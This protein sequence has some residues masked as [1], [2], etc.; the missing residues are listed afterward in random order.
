[1]TRGSFDD[2]RDAL[3]AF[4]SGWDRDRYESG[5][6]QD[7]QLDQWARG[8]VD[9]YF[10][11]YSSWSQL[12]DA[13]WEAMSYRSMN[14]LGFV[15][16]QFG[17]ALLID[18]GYYDD[19]VFY[20]N[21]AASNTWDGTWTGKNGVTSLED[22]MTK[23]AQ[24][25]AIREAFGFNLKIIQ[26][27]LANQGKSL[28]DYIGTTR[29]YVEG[30]QN[31]E[32]PLTLTGIMAAAHLRGAWGTLNLLLSGS[33]ST[34]E[35][36]TS[37]LRYVKQFGGYDAPSIEDVIAYFTDRKTGDE[38]LGRPGS[39]DGAPGGGLGDGATKEDADVV[40]TWSWGQKTVKTDFDP[41]SDSIFID[42]ISADHL[43]ISEVNGSTVFS[44]PSNNQSL[45]LQGVALSD[46]T[47]E[48]FTIL[49]ASAAAKVSKLI[50][51]G[52]S[53]GG[54]KDDGSGDDPNVD[55]LV[56]DSNG[57]DESNGDEGL[58]RPGSDDGA[59]GGGLGDGA[60]KEDADVVITWSWGQ[61][62]VKT[63]FDPAS[64]SIFIDWISADHL[65]ISEVNGSTVFSIP[66]N[67][68]SLTL[69]GVALSDLTRENFT[70]LD[71]SAAAK[72]SKLIANGDSGGGSKDDGSGDDPNVDNLVDDSNGK[73]ESNGDEGGRG[74][75]HEDHKDH[76]DHGNGHGN[77]RDGDAAQMVMIG[78]D[79]VSREITDFDP[80]KDMVHLLKGVTGDRFEISGQMSGGS[81]SVRIVVSNEDG[82]PI[83]V[84]TLRGV[85]IDDLSL[86]NFSVAEQTALNEVVTAINAT[87]T[88]PPSDGGGFDFAYDSDG[89][90]PPQT[91]GST[92]KGGVKYEADINADDIVNFDPDKDEIDFGDN[93][94][95]AMILTKLPSGEV[96]IDTPWSS[97]IQI[98]QGVS[99]QDLSLEN[100]GIVRNEH[101]RQD[102]GGVLSWELGVGPRENDTVYI[103]SHEYGKHETIDDFDPA[104]MKISFL[105][106]GTREQ[107]SVRD[108]PEGLVIQTLPGGQSFTFTGLRLADLSPGNLEFHYDQVME[109]NLEA[110]FGFDQEDVTLVDRTALLTPEAPAGQTTDGFQTRE[111]VGTPGTGERD[112]DSGGERDGG[113]GGERDS[114]SGG[115]RDSGSGGELDDGRVELEWN[116]AATEVIDGFDPENDI[117][118]FGQMSADHLRITEEDGDLVIKVL[119]NGGQSYRLKDVQAEDMRSENL[120]AAPNNNVIARPGGVMEQLVDL[121]FPEVGF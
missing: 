75:G 47:R 24:E 32:V 72:V 52:D 66:S 51:N 120:E 105:Y 59:P 96:A 2:F 14:T 100:F 88:P 85:D 116:W 46:L 84:T 4:E 92:A 54:S 67:N 68:Q 9:K 109:D 97:A 108:T 107:L 41:A 44:I 42:W 61:K 16:Y 118:D 77:G 76:K 94:V 30:G 29:S 10:P 86:S 119:N 40:I 55:N 102:I 121:G 104:S 5:N 114:G 95:H 3:R 25:V 1:M 80:D 19:D 56:D 112:G 63:D 22:F 99:Y 91:T 43:S 53:G 58:G 11:Q 101:L 49:D 15:G 73:D 89:L 23:E 50:A 79:S 36:G 18:L 31:V 17:E 27:G 33:V 8:T 103:R 81:P 48:N 34:D 111:G 6:I 83:S 78:L 39:D 26:E 60:T 13:E 74:N 106:F 38:G 82:T 113:S 87:V 57:K 93:S 12:T 70:I 110:P 45:T 115:E 35:F 69:Q 65:S 20:G 64:D 117:L 37:I 62:T 90:N 71:A 21:G 7:W 98:L 28:A